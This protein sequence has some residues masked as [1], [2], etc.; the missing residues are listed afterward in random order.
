MGIQF[1]ILYFA[2][3][4]L[5]AGLIT[6][7]A[8]CFLLPWEDQESRKPKPSLLLGWDK[9]AEEE[10][11]IAIPDNPT[12]FCQEQRKQCQDGT[13]HLKLIGSKQG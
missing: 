11:F 10:G 1:Y 13:G 5:S 9:E 7:F 6:E 3:V 4:F 2:I 8:L 12:C